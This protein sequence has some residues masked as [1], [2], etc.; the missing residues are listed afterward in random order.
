MRFREVVKELEKLG[1]TFDRVSGSHYLYKHVDGLRPIILCH[2][3]NNHTF[4]ITL[5]NKIIKEA[6]LSIVMGIEA[7]ENRSKTTKKG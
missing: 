4:G 5:V 7:R 2:K 1:F 6:K 3:A